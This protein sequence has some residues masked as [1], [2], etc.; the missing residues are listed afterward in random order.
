M[1]EKAAEMRRTVAATIQEMNALLLE[2]RPSLLEQ[3]G[4]VPALAGLCEAYRT[5]LGV[6]LV[7]D[8]RQVQLPAAAEHAAFRAAQEGLANAV[9]HSAAHTI[10]LSLQPRDGHA[11]LLIA[12]DGRG[13]DSARLGP[14]PGLGLRLMRDRISELGG[15]LAV[16]STPGRGTELKVSLPVVA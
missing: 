16:N 13:F 11:E 7:E 1:R 4:L 10:R 6:S 14:G 12:D 9:R 2:L 15:T 8:L 3:R 5:R